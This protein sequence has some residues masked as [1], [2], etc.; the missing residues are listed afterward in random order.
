MGWLDK[1]KGGEYRLEIH[2]DHHDLTKTVILKVKINLE[3]LR[4]RGITTQL[5]K[6]LSSESV[7]LM[8]LTTYLDRNGYEMREKEKK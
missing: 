8:I 2:D 7:A 4:D 6:T 5:M 3:D 1:F